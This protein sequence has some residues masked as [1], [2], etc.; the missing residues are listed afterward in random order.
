MYAQI[1]TTTLCEYTHKNTQQLHAQINTARQCK[2]M[3][4]NT[5]QHSIQLSTRNVVMSVIFSRVQDAKF[6]ILLTVH[7]SI[8]LV[9]N[10]PDALFQCIYFTSLRV[11]S[12][13]VLIIRRIN[14]I[15]TSSGVYHSVYVT[16]RYACQERTL[17]T[18]TPD[19]HI[20]R[21]IHTR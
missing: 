19:S 17:L 12:I 11:S 21:A 4:D 7:L 18:G 10:Q 8:I 1:F 5:E 20:H 3:H 2:C 15:N 16:V 6:Y 13:P 9:N 14:C